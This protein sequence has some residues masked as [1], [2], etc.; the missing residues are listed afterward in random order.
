VV[1]TL[2]PDIAAAKQAIELVRQRKPDKRPELATSIG[3]PVAQSS[4]NGCCCGSPTA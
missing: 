3:D 1:A 2:P 4:S